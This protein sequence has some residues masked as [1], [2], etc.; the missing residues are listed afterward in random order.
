MSRVPWKYQR[1]GIYLEAARGAGPGKAA[2]GQRGCHAGC[3]EALIA[4]ATGGVIG[5]PSAASACRAW[6]RSGVNITRMSWPKIGGLARER[7]SNGMT[8]P[9]SG[10][11]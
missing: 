6:F 1:A 7:D 10:A 11:A 5:G 2:A 4:I 3:S 9:D 8:S